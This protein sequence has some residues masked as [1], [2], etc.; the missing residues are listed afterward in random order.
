M[1]KK[2][3]NHNEWVFEQFQQKY[4]KK[5]YRNSIIHV[6]IIE[7]VLV[8]NSEMKSFNTA[9]GCL[10]FSQKISPLEFHVFDEIRKELGGIIN[11][12][13]QRFFNF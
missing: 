10:L 7:G 13:N 11:F 3:L 1:S 4:L 5:S 6:S 9:I 12:M 8:S 2:W